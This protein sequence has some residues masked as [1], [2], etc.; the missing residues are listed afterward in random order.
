M[1]HFFTI[2]WPDAHSDS[3]KQLWFT[4]LSDLCIRG[5]DYFGIEKTF[6]SISTTKTCQNAKLVSL[7]G[8]YRITKSEFALAEK[9]DYGFMI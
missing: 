2:L 5:S 1:G 6:W 7:T 8:R 9:N 4:F 3:C